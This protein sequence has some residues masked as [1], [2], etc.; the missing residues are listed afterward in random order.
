MISDG[1]FR[2]RA[3]TL[4]QRFGAAIAEAAQRDKQGFQAAAL[5]A[6]NTGCAYLLLD[7]ASGRSRGR[8]QSV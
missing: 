1:A 7:A 8:V 3:L 5:L 2:A 4:T 6:T